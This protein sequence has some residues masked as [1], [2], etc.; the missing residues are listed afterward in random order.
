MLR[1]WPAIVFSVLAVG[2]PGPALAGPTESQLQLLLKAL[3]YDRLLPTRCPEGVNLGVLAPAGDPTALVAARAVAAA[4][5]GKTLESGVA[6]RARAVE[7]QAP[8][9]LGAA[10]KSGALNT[11]F[12]LLA[13]KEQVP[14][15]SQLAAQHRVLLISDQPEFLGEGVALAVAAQGGGDRLFINLQGAAAQGARFDTRLLRIAEVVGSA[16]RY[17]PPEAVRK[18]RLKGEDPQYPGI[19]RSAKLQASVVVKLFIDADGRIEK[20]QFLKTH[21]VFEQAVRSALQGWAFAPVQL[22][23][24][25]AATHTVLKFDFRLDQ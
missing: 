10:V 19:A 21:E 1:Q 20:L 25:N 18:R 23:G 5:D 7:F 2:L 15:L 13:S 12:L 22:D 16:S 24:K 17:Q 11:L 8:T 6:L 9:D 4:L 14:E 3:A